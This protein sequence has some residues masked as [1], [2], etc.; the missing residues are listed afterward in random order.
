M[1]NDHCYTNLIFESAKKIP[2]KAT[3]AKQTAGSSKQANSQSKS[4]SSKSAKDKEKVQSDS[5]DS[6]N[7]DE[8]QEEEQSDEEISYSESDDEDDM[9]FNVNDRFGRH[10][11]KR[12][13]KYRKHKQKQ[14]TF[15]DFL[16]TGE[17]SIPDDDQKKKYGKKQKKS[18]VSNVKT[19]GNTKLSQESSTFKTNRPIKKAPVQSSSKDPSTLSFSVL[20]KNEL[21][22]NFGMPTVRPEPNDSTQATF[23]TPK[24]SHAQAQEK[25][26][27]RIESIRKELETSCQTSFPADLI[28]DGNHKEKLLPVLEKDPSVDLEA[29]LKELDSTDEEIGDAIFA[30]LGENALD[31]L[32]SESNLIDFEP[33]QPVNVVAAMEKPE[34]KP[35]VVNSVVQKQSTLTSSHPIIA[36]TTSTLTRESTIKVVGR[37]GRIVILPPIEKPATRGSKRKSVSDVSNAQETLSA[38]LTPIEASLV[39][40]PAPKTIKIEKSPVKETNDSKN[41]SRRSSLNR[42]ESGKSR[43]SISGVLEEDTD[44]LNSDASGASEDDPERLWCICKQPHNNKFMICCDKCKLCSVVLLI[45]SY[46]H[47]FIHVFIQNFRRRMVPR[48]MCKC[49]EEHGQSHRA[50]EERMDLSKMQKRRNSFRRQEAKP[51]ETHKIFHEEFL[52]SYET[53]CNVYRLQDKTKQ[54]SFEFLQ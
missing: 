9:D 33:T 5:E 30:V 8:K 13:R 34:S 45:Y 39:A 22:A 50:V 46:I 24:N 25:E 19:T 20:E 32:L 26:K 40:V 54:R 21:D 4:T 7:D 16:E 48:K 53:K 29:S 23:A 35:V 42:S 3:T 18:I 44:D 49:H 17:I 43:N 6:E 31:E 11:G 10:K 28:K 51:I 37:N 41:S 27:E 2:V 36:T 12:K 1:Q 14:S 47:S 15:K 38:S 52:K